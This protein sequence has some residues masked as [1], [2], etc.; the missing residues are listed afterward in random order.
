MQASKNNQLGKRRDSGSNFQ[1]QSQEQRHK[2]QNGQYILDE[3]LEP[4]EDTQQKIL[5]QLKQMQ[6]EIIIIES[7]GQDDT[8]SDDEEDSSFNVQIKDMMQSLNQ[9]KSTEQNQQSNQ[10]ERVNRDVVL[11]WLRQQYENEGFKRALTAQD[12]IGLL[13][14]AGFSSRQMDKSIPGANFEQFCRKFEEALNMLRLVSFYWNEENPYVIAGFDC[15][16]ARAEG[17]LQ[18]LPPGTFLIRMSFGDFGKLVVSVISSNFANPNFVVHYSISVKDL[19][20]K[21]L[22]QLVMSLKSAEMLFDV[23]S[24]K[25]IEKSKVFVEGSLRSP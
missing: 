21:K 25:L 14:Q 6:P 13:K 7:G 5:N 24:L 15:D 8:L 23:F 11:D 2:G 20:S 3:I 17:A 18:T 22:G 10:L 1:Q 19:G 12:E 4:V 16:K 9:V